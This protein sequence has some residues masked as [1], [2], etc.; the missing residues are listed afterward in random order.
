MRRRSRYQRLP[1]PPQRRKRSTPAPSLSLS[2]FF[3]CSVLSCRNVNGCMIRFEKSPQQLCLETHLLHLL[4][5]P[6]RRGRRRA[7]RT[8]LFRPLPPPRNITSPAP[9]RRP[10]VP[11]PLLL[12]ELQYQK[13]TRRRMKFSFSASSLPKRRIRQGNCSVVTPTQVGCCVISGGRRPPPSPLSR[14][15][16][17][18]TC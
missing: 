4:C 17:F 3:S 13:M 6:R 8:L 7:R 12:R 5:P 2:L 15:I 14:G 10:P 11:R 1:P 18:T 16:A 9:R